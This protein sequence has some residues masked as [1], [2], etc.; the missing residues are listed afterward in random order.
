MASCPHTQTR[1]K[2]RVRIVIRLKTVTLCF[3]TTISY[4]TALEGDMN[5][6]REVNFNNFFL[7]ADDFGK[8]TI[9]ENECASIFTYMNCDGIEVC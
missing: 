1:D 5:C 8:T 3:L 2:E 7:L 6:D 4:A 9:V